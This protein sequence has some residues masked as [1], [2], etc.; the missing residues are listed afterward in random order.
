MSVADK[1]EDGRRDGGVYDD[2]R[3]RR[4]ECQGKFPGSRVFLD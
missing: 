4:I 3:I 2:T 1:R